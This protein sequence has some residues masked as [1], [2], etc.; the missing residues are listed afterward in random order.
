MIKSFKKITSAILFTSAFS[1]GLTAQ[2]LKVPAPSPL[3]TIKQEFALSSITVEYS[4]PSTKGRVIFGDL[5]PYGKVWRTGANASTKITF[6]EDIKLEGNAVKAGTYA[7]YTIPNK[8]SWEIIIYSDLNLGGNVADYKKEN[9]VAHFTVKPKTLGEKIETFSIE[10]ANIT[11]T[12]VVIALTWENTRIELNVVADIDATIMKNIDNLVVKDNRPYFQAAR[13]Y[14][15]TDKDLVKAKEWVDMAIAS[16]PKAYWVYMLKANI[17]SKMKDKKGAIA[18]A[19]MV[20]SL[21]T[22]EKDD[23]YVAQAQKL[24]AENKK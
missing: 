20:V 24:I 3:Q 6:G 13:Y 11:S 7:L 9:D 17:Q 19:E 14:Y 4:R 18:T 21:A 2:S 5:V 12:T 10:F 1:L 16:N 23:N 15:E 8:D 22:A